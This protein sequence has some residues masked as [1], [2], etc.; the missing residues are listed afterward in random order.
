MSNTLETRVRALE[1]K[2]LRGEVT[3]TMPG[4]GTQAISASSILAAYRDQLNG[5][6][7]PELAAILASTSD[8]SDAMGF[9]QMTELIRAI[10]GSIGNLGSGAAE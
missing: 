2:L 3:L 1:G 8:D 4:G 5:R 6:Q 7:S 10:A 9:G